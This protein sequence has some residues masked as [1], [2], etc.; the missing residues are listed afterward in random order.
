MDTCSVCCE[1]FNK[2]TRK[3]VT[4][5]FCDYESCKTCTQTYL[6]SSTD[7]PHCMNCKNELN[8]S[9]I[10]SF[11]TKRFRN[12]EYKKHRENIL[13]EKELAKMPETQPKVERIL[14][15]REIRTEY[16][17]LMKYLKNIRLEKRDAI[18][19]NYPIDAY[20]DIELELTNKIDNLVYEMNTLRSEYDE[21]SDTSERNFVR[22][23]PSE[24]CRGFI[25][26]NWK[27]GLCKQQFCKHCNEKVEENH[28]CNP[29]T[30]ETITL[31]NKDTKPCPKC[32]I[33]IHKIDGCAQMWCT[34][35]NTAFDWRSGK[36]ETGRIHNPHFFE[37]QKRS[38]EH[39][40]IPCGGRPSFLELNDNNAPN[41]LLDVT[42][43]LRQID[44]DIMYKYGN[45]YDD[46][47]THLRISYMLKSISKE[48]FK[49]ELQRRDK[50]K[51]KIQDI[52][53]ILEMFTNTVGDFLRQWVVDKTDILENI[54]ELVEYSNEII[55]GIR[56]RYNSSTPNF[57]YFP[58]TLL[59]LVSVQV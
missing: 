13:F 32:G 22:M 53:D 41:E 34:S 8:R 40:D 6:I 47:N 51:D 2:T 11:C 3:K 4:C 58:R 15:M 21:P 36:I 28:I 52:R 14:R 57:I 27:C 39:A 33:M 5:P 49:I 48:D 1:N 45:I 50:F 23:C 56:N 10:D 9:F 24:E 26:E 12:V 59:T 55:Q 42:L 35:C 30:V 19:M 18:I 54:Y 7:N 31:I 46:N 29:K 38:R 25:E 37:F 16:H 20:Q 44:R 43:L 17:E